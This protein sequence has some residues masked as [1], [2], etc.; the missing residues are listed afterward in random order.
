MI[1]NN[2]LKNI[3][4]IWILFINSGHKINMDCQKSR[5]FLYQIKKKNNEK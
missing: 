1:F 5:L 4:R 3:Y 2:L